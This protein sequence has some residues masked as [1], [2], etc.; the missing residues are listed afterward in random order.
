MARE[1][2]EDDA[3]VE[4]AEDV[5]ASAATASAMVKVTS[6]NSSNNISQIL[7]ATVPAVSTAISAAAAKAGS[8]A[9]TLSPAAAAAAATVPAT[10]YTA[11]QGIGTITGLPQMRP[12]CSLCRPVPHQISCAVTI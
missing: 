6:Y 3:E 8:A 5:G 1:G 11:L 10:T 7:P 12:T 4:M 9:A 2:Q